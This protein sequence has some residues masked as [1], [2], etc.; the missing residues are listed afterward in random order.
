MPGRTTALDGAP[1]RDGPP[2]TWD[3]TCPR[4]TT[5][6]TLTNPT[7]FY[8]LRFIQPT[9]HLNCGLAALIRLM[10]TLALGFSLPV[11]L[12]P[13]AIRLPQ[14]PVF[15]LSGAPGRILSL[16][17]MTRVALV[18]LIYIR[19]TFNRQKSE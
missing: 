1:G 15:S 12:V 9:D 19:H 4:M 11:L 13:P 7:P 2:T 6:S 10:L 17:Q 14:V 3:W 16:R 18:A 5:R 8:N